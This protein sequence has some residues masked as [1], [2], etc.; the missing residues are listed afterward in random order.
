MWG[1]T[2]TYGALTAQRMGLS[3]AVVTSIGPDLDTPS[4]QRGIPFHVVPASETTTFRNIYSEG[5]RVQVVEAVADPITPRDVPEV[6]RGAP[7]VLLGPLVGEVGY[8]LARHFPGSTV[9]AC[10]Q[11]WLR[12][13]DGRGRVAATSWDG[14]EVLPNVDAAVVSAEDAAD[15]AL[16]ERW[17]ELAPVLIVTMGSRGARLHAGGRWHDVAA[18]RAEERDPTGAGD[19]FAAAYMITYRESGDLLAAARFA[20]CAAA[21]SVEGVGTT[22][23]PTRTE[24]EA[25]LALLQEGG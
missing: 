8:D 23:I 21:L 1:G 4:R 18:F 7:M 12:S 25:R 19:V 24:V 10:M 2:V 9:V 3:P 17:A 14:A 6:W 13:W 22:A 11:G 20:S 16:I 15:A 5:Q